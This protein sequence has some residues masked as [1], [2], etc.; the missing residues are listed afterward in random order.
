MLD[1]WK[2][3]SEIAFKRFEGWKSGSPPFFKRVV[4][5]QIASAGTRRALLERATPISRSTCRRRIFP[6]W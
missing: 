3:G 1:S 2:P 5:R 4:D 6:S